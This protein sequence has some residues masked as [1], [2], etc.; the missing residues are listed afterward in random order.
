MPRNKREGT[1]KFDQIKS[2]PANPPDGLQPPV[3]GALC[4]KKKPDKFLNHQLTPM[5]WRPRMTIYELLKIKD[6]NS[7]GIL[8]MVK[9]INGQILPEAKASGYSLYGIF[10]GL[11]GLATNELYLMAMREDEGPS[12]GGITPLSQLIPEHNFN[13]RENYQLSPTVRPTE[14][15][16]R[17]RDGIYVFR[18][19]NIFNRNVDEIVKLSD[20]AWVLFEGGFES[21]IQC[22]FAER[23]RSQE[24]GRMLLLTW[25]R[26]LS[27]WEASRRPP[28]EARKRFLK[29][30]KL[31]IEAIPIATRLYHIQ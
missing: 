23:D 13:L 3:I 4:V 8:N 16:M 12:S 30:H 9:T 18:W 1:Y 21:E 14:H 28:E 19:F 31:T 26:D 2:Q 10:F 7:N 15:T 17:T 24:Q 27:V 20:E 22:L 11:F 25:Y 29:R 5:K 6:T